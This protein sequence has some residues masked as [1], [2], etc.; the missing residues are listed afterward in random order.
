MAHKLLSATFIATLL[1]L[2]TLPLALA[3]NTEVKTFYGKT[4]A[5]PLTG[6]DYVTYQCVDA[7]CS[8]PTS[9]TPLTSGNT[10]GSNQLSIAYPPTPD[11]THYAQY[12][13]KQCYWPQDWNMFAFGTF[14]DFANFASNASGDQEKF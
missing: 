14:D 9:F 7:A 11:V 6:V 13:Y 3:V 10:G 5:N 12:F 8:A 1:L 4:T 2:F